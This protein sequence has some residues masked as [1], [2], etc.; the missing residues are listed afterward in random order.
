M[1]KF[2]S[3]FSFVPGPGLGSHKFVQKTNSFR[4]FG[5]SGDPTHVFFKT[6]HIPHRLLLQLCLLETGN[7]PGIEIS[8][9]KRL[10]ILQHSLILFYLSSFGK[11]D[12]L[13][14]K[15]QFPRL[16]TDLIEVHLQNLHEIWC[17]IFCSFIAIKKWNAIL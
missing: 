5:W 8:V 17:M 16:G 15:R 13:W 12:F 4:R 9:K 11:R 1:V 14:K 2:R 7:R 6:S 10:N 3:K